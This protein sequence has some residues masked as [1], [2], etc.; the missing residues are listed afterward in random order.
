M[1]TE[2]VPIVI[3]SHGGSSDDQMEGQVAIR[4][5]GSGRQT[6]FQSLLLRETLDVGHNEV[7]D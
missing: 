3:R 2:Y 5:F 7:C 4:I 1:H 6:T